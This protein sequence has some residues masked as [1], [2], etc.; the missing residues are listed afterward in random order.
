M[1]PVVFPPKLLHCSCGEG[2][3]GYDIHWAGGS[4]LTASSSSP[5]SAPPSLSLQFPPFLSPY[6]L[7]GAL[8]SRTIAP[9]YCLHLPALTALYC[10]VLDWPTR[11]GKLASY[12]FLRIGKEIFT[13]SESLQEI[14]VGFGCSSLQQFNCCSCEESPVAEL[15]FSGCGIPWSCRITVKSTCPVW[16]RACLCIANHRNQS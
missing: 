5:A 9:N 15:G 11:R 12:Y 14:L 4:A 1:F 3:G 2:V 10:T 6:Y 16:L 13:I 8:R 7:A